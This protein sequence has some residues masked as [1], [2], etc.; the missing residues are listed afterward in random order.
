M[1]DASIACHWRITCGRGGRVTSVYAESTRR[2]MTWE[3]NGERP[4]DVRGQHLELGGTASFGSPGRTGPFDGLQAEYARVPYAHTNL[5]RLPDSVSD[6]QAIPLGPP[7]CGVGDER[8][9]R[10]AAAPVEAHVVSEVRD[11]ERRP[12][13][14]GPFRRSNR[15]ANAPAANMGRRALR[16]MVPRLHCRGGPGW[17]SSGGDRSGG[18]GWGCGWPG[19]RVAASWSSRS[20]MRS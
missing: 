9:P 17:G 13:S 15:R 14:A 20:S 4:T 7:V 12:S 3:S 1:I 6:A 18:S 10:R 5:T 16:M 11:H 2:P 19:R 8:R